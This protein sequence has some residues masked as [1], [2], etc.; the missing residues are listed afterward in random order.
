MGGVDIQ[1]LGGDGR[2]ERVVGWGGWGRVRLAS[3]GRQANISW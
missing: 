3:L 1:I 2:C